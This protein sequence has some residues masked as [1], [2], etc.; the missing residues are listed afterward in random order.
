MRHI[1]LLFA[2]LLWGSAATWLHG[3]E[4]LHHEDEAECKQVVHANVAAAEISTSSFH[5]IW[6]KHTLLGVIAVE[7][8]AIPTRIK[9]PFSNKA[10]PV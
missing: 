7:R 9:H 4:H 5:I 2:L 3:F 6:T 1:W 8:K 10:P